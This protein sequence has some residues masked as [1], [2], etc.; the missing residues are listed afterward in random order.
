MKT[1]PDVI[2]RGWRHFHC[3]ECEHRWKWPSR[4][5]FSPS[6]ENCPR[7]Y[8]WC[9]PYQVEL[10]ATIPCDNMGNLTVPWNWNG[11][12][13]PNDADLEAGG[14]CNPSREVIQKNTI[15]GLL[16]KH[17]I[18][19]SLAIE[20]AEGYDNYATSGNVSRFVAALEKLLFP[21]D[22]TL[23]TEGAAQDS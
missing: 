12:E 11:I 19:Q 20:D 13:E 18:I 23:P 6:G 5:V 7:C 10:D 4:D 1:N 16:I 15:A 21:N 9:H 17:G 22:Q 14:C 2:R 8:E 3:S